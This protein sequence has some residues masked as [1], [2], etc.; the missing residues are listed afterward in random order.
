MTLHWRLFLSVALLVSTAAC[1]EKIIHDLSEAEA[2]RIVTKLHDVRLTGYKEK[3]SDGNWSI[4][5]E[6][7]SAVQAIKFLNDSRVIKEEGLETAKS[8]TFLNSREE[9]RFHFERNLSRSI[10]RTLLSLPNVLEARVHLNLPE[11]D[12]ILGQKLANSKG[13]GSVL[14]LSRGKLSNEPSQIAG[15]VA[16]ASGVPPEQVV[17]VTSAAAIDE[18]S[19]RPLPLQSM[20]P[21]TLFDEILRNPNL[22]AM[23]I[24]LLLLIAG[25]ALLLRKRR[26]RQFFKEGLSYAT[27]PDAAI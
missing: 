14:L 22:Q 21:Q 26:G 6:K 4:A 11:V 13:S 10:E 8:G 7:Q 12:P 15:I 23:A 20:Q 3:Q 9:Q 1:R 25:L 27:E 2:N 19:P 16:G 5:V 18:T 24:A 17:V